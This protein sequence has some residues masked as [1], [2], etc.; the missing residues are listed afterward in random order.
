[1]LQALERGAS[2]TRGPFVAALIGQA[3]GRVGRVQSAA[4]PGLEEIG[5]WR[6]VTS[7]DFAVDVAENRQSE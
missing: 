5:F 7:S 4:E 2:E 6:Y 1:V 3:F